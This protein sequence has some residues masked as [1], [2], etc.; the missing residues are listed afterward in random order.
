MKNIETCIASCYTL[1]YIVL[2]SLKDLTNDSQV[3]KAFELLESKI[4]NSEKE[5]K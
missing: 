4:P 2:S 3:Q 5:V 1:L